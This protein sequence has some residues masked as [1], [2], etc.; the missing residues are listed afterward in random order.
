MQLVR[1][2]SSFDESLSR[3]LS[4]CPWASRYGAGK[5]QEKEEEKKGSQI[6]LYGS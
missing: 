3:S 2:V 1:L 6:L 5:Q 4:S